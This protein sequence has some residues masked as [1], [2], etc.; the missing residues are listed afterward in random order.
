MPP[1][2]HGGRSRPTGAVTV[3]KVVAPGAQVELPM[4]FHI[5]PL[6]DNQEVLAHLCREHYLEKRKAGKID[7]KRGVVRADHCGGRCDE[8]PRPKTL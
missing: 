6:D 5:T 8:C 7:G 4:H 2:T 3:E 1:V